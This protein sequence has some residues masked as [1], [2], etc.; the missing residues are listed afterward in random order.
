MN[1]AQFLLV[2]LTEECAEVSQRALKQIQFGRYE[3]QKGQGFT[4]GERLRGELLD[5]FVI[6]K[7]LEES[8]G[9]S[10]FTGE[11]FD[12]AY[13]MKKRKMQKYLDLSY[14]LGQLEKITL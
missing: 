12:D 5:L 11:D 13:D 14:E 7:M 6:V 8:D 4:N 2:K 9:F 10:E 1:K 3:V